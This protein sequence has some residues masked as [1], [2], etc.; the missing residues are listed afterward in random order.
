MRPVAGRSSG[1]NMRPTVRQATRAVLEGVTFAIRDCRDALAAT[2]TGWS[3][4]WLWVAARG[5]TIG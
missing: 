1:W 5:R 3:G 2:G 4:F